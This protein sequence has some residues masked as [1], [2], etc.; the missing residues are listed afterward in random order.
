M[1]DVLEMPTTIKACHNEIGKLRAQLADARD[2]LADKERENSRLQSELDDMEEESREAENE[3]DDRLVDV[4]H[5]FLDECERVG[6]LRYRVPESD[7]ANS[8]IIGLHEM[9]GRNP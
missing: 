4:V 9:A 5:Q 8:A 7:R 2:D 3:A 1:T 6:V